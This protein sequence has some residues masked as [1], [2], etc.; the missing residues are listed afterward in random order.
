MLL[1]HVNPDPTPSTPFTCE[2]DEGRPKNGI[3]KRSSTWFVYT[4]MHAA[5][6]KICLCTIMPKRHPFTSVLQARI[7]SKTHCNTLQRQQG[8]MADCA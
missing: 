6:H 8:A 1:S 3:S 7:L 4:Y 2:V 5:M